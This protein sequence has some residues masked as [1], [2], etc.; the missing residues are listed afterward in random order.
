MDDTKNVAT[1]LKFMAQALEQAKLSS[2]DGNFPVGAVLVIDGEV[3]DKSRNLIST[4]ADWI[5][6][7]EMN[8]INKHSALIKQARNAGGECIIYTTSDHTSAKWDKAKEL[9]QNME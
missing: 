2:L 9:M 4:K 6:H 1:D 8:L 7:A 5:S 3:I